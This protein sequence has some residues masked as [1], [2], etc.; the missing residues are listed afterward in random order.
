MATAAPSEA[1]RFAI[2]APIPREP[3]VTS[4]TLPSS[5]FEFVV[6]LVSYFNV[7]RNGDDFGFPPLYMGSVFTARGEKG[8]GEGADVIADLLT[9]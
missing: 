2:A 4:A 5:F 1:S 9:S 6:V 3:P 8:F 7:D